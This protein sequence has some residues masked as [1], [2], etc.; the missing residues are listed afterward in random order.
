[1]ANSPLRLPVYNW[2]VDLLRSKKAGRNVYSYIN[3]SASSNAIAHVEVLKPDNPNQPLEARIAA[4]EKDMYKIK[5]EIRDQANAINKQENSL[6]HLKSDMVRQGDSLKKDVRADM[7]Q[8]HT[9]N[10]MPA[11]VGLV[12]V[13]FGTSISTL[14]PEIY[15]F[16]S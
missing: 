9:S 13:A 14:A 3:A 4:I 10:F 1:M 11:L 6:K 8:A 5:Q 12:L 15:Y 16:L 7:E 2:L